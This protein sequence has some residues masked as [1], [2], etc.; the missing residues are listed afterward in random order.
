MQT[1]SPTLTMTK[2]QEIEFIQEITVLARER[3][4]ATVHEALISLSVPLEY[5]ITSDFLG[6]IAVTNLLDTARETR[7]R[8]SQGHK[9]LVSLRDQMKETERRAE[10][11]EARVNNCT[12]TL[13]EITKRAEGVLHAAQTGITNAHRKAS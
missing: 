12:S 7:E 10:R 1:D 3:G 11:A 4:A 2:A 6:E 5:A 9:D 13:L 8:L